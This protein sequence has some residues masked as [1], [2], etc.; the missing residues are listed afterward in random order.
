MIASFHG[1]R[2]DCKMTEED[3]D[4]CMENAMFFGSEKSIV[5]AD[6]AEMTKHCE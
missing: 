5:P 4:T 6:D 1:Y 2:S 3:L